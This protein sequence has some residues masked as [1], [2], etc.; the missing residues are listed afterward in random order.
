VLRDDIPTQYRNIG[1]ASSSVAAT[2]AV[3]GRVMAL[4]KVVAGAP[5]AIVRE[6]SEV[7]LPLG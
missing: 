7:R 6:S 5:V 3:R 2:P 4:G 1:F